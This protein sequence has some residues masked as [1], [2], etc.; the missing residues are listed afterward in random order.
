MK[1]PTTL[2]QI[3]TMLALLPLVTSCHSD[4]PGAKPTPQAAPIVIIDTDLASSTD[5]VIAI[6]AACNLHKVG[7]I[8]LAA[9]MVNRNGDTNTKIADILLTYQNHPEVKIGTT[10]HGPE[11]PKV[12]C[13]YYKAAEPSLYPDEPLFART[14]TDE[15]ISRLPDAA[16]LYR[17]ILS[18]SDDNSI[19]IVSIGFAS[20]LARLLKSQPDVVSPLSGLELVKRKVKEIHLQAGQFDTDNEPDYN[21]SQDAASAHA[22]MELCPVPMFFSPQ[23]VG[24]NFNYTPEM[25]LADLSAAGMT[26]S[27][28]YHFYNHHFIDPGQRMWDAVTLLQLVHPGLFDLHGPFDLTV[29]DQMILHAN[30]PTPTSTRYYLTHKP[31]HRASIMSLIRRYTTQATE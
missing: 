10:T 13:D 30:P 3:A 25:I 17:E 24:D 31:H 2:L 22:L 19:V 7:A 11:N 4:D 26:D 6:I 28:L 12:W 27:P 9:I 14:I 15:Q 5:D 1:L 16:M 18:H 23:E 21:F 29:D 8:D 20:N